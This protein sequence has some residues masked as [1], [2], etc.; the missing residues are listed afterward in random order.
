MLVTCGAMAEAEGRFFADRSPE[1]WMDEAGRLCA[2]A[3]LDFFPE[4]GHA[5]VFCGRGNNG[6]DALVVAR[7][8]RRHGWSVALHFAAGVESLAEL[9]RKKLAEFEAE[10][11]HRFGEWLASRPVV[12]IDGL[13]GIG[14]KGEL[15]GSIRDL[16]RRINE[17]RQ[18]DWATVFAIDL[19]SGFDAD[20]GAAGADAV[21]AD[22]TLSITAAKVGFAEDGAANWIGRL[23]EIPLD[24]P[25]PAG[26]ETRRFLFPSNLLPRLRRRSFDTHKGAAGRV[27]IVAGGRGLTGAA[28]LSAL[29]A[30]RGG[31]G[32]VTLCVPEEVHAIVAAK[33]S[34]EVMVRPIRSFAEVAEL[35]ADV[36]AVGPGLGT[37]PPPGMAAFLA[38][39]PA[40]IVVDAD[41]L[42]GLA[43]CPEILRQLPPNRLLTPH[44]GE[45]VR[46]FGG[47]SSESRCQLARRFADTT[48]TTLL[49]KGARSVVASPGRAIELNTTGHPGMASGGMGDVLTGLCAALSAQGLDLHDAASV[50]SWLLGRAAELAVR[51]GGIAPESLAA[52]MV[53]EHLGAALRS[54]RMPEAV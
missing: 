11:P 45:M 50:G 21:V 24:I 44:P 35:E 28:V 32:L 49:L 38:A 31:A 23:V 15:R 16:A 3:V 53:A 54:L 10:P 52:P 9:P 43:R 5:E 13:L 26:D 40:P 25:P 17:L 46:L 36:L 29:G 30:S 18:T 1:P 34:A 20:S 4:P 42:N 8:L 2:A 51:D 33:A 39:H 14:A 19:P 48:G 7:W 41:A 6:G 22:F 12:V 37:A 47:A 27:A